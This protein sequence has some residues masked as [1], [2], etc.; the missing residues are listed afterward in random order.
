MQQ[1]ERARESERERETEIERASERKRT[2]ERESKREREAG[3]VV[4]TMRRT[5]RFIVSMEVTMLNVWIT[6]GELTNRKWQVD[7]PESSGHCVEC[8][9]H[10]TRDVTTHNTTQNDLQ[11]ILGF[12]IKRKFNQDLA[13]NEVYLTNSSTLLAKNMLF[14][15]LQCEDSFNL[16]S[17]SYT[18][19]CHATPPL[20]E[21]YGERSQVYH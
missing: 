20:T 17:F 4:T 19:T 16:I 12:Y 15:K 5:S 7:S 8:L 11:S 9:D 21:H 3:G 2:R 14:G 13:G 1:S 10:L 18:I 6:C